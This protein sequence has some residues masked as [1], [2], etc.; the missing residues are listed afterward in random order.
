MPESQSNLYRRMMKQADNSIYN[1]TAE[2]YGYYCVLMRADPILAAALEK[3]IG[4]LDD[5]RKQIRLVHRLAWEADDEQFNSIGEALKL[6]LETRSEIFG[7][8]RLC[9][10]FS[11]LWEASVPASSR[12]LERRAAALRRRSGSHPSKPEE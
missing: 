3:C 6:I 2:L 8:G 5:C 11:Q 7:K 12:L 10:D 4:D 1:A 9:Q